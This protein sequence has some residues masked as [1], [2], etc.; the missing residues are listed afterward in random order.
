MDDFFFDGVDEAVI[1][2]EKDKAR[3]LRKTSWWQAK[4]SAG[5]CYYC[6]CQFSAR[7]LTMDHITPL[8]RGGHSTKGNIVPACKECN[9]KKRSML[10][11]EWQQL[12]DTE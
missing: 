1:R 10:P 11:I 9:T 8:A 5:L 7:E 3:K 4:I 12:L 6:G 2:Q